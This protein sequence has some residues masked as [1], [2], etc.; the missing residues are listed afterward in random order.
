MQLNYRK[1]IQE[2]CTRDQ[3]YFLISNFRRVLNAVGFLLGNSMTSEFYMRT[4]RKALLV[5]SSQAGRYLPVYEELTEGSETSTHKIQIPGNYPEE[6]VRSYFCYIQSAKFWEIYKSPT[7]TEIILK[8][9]TMGS[10]LCLCYFTQVL[11]SSSQNCW[12]SVNIQDVT[13]L[14]KINFI[15]DI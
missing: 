14:Q 8:Y 3:S 7:P 2:T 6:S 9:D 1:Q 12:I 5:P 15:P 4:L 10:D 11:K 13:N